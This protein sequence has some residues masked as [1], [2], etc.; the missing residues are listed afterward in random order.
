MTEEVTGIDLV[1]SQILIAQ[2]MPLAD[3]EI[4]LR[5][6]GRRPHATASPSSAA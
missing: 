3:P 6:P 4:G 2:G 1:K 5:Q